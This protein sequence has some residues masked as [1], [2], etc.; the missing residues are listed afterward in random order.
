MAAAMTGRSMMKAKADALLISFIIG[1]AFLMLWL[2][3]YLACGGW[4]YSIHSRLF[5]LSRHEFDVINYCGMMAVKLV[6]FFFFLIPYAGLKIA[7]RKQ[8]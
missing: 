3:M 6:L 2:I 7:G 5:S 1:A 4:I 8:A